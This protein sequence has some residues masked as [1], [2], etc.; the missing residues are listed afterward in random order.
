MPYLLRETLL[1][2]LLYII[3]YDQNFKFYFKL[4]SFLL[5]KN[6]LKRKL[7]FAKKPNA[8]EVKVSIIFS[9][10]IFNTFFLFTWKLFF[11]FFF[12]LKLD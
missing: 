5:D 10:K 7:T 8:R 11:H 1:S 3:V 4:D 9:K 2:Y 6:M 12:C